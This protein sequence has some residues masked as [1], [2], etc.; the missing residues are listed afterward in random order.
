[1]KEKIKN[2]RPFVLRRIVKKTSSVRACL[3]SFR[4]VRISYIFLLSLV[5]FSAV[6]NAIVFPPTTANAIAAQPTS[7]ADCKAAGGSWTYVS[8]GGANPFVCTIAMVKLM[9]PQEEAAS[10]SYY[11]ALQPCVSNSGGFGTVGM[12][13]DI[14]TNAA[15]D[16]NAAPSTWFNNDGANHTIYPYQKAS[17]A[18]IVTK[19]LSLWGWGS[20]YKSFLTSIGY[21]LEGTNWHGPSDGNA[22]WNQFSAVIRSKVYS[23]SFSSGLP[24]R[25]SAATYVQALD[26]FTS[27]RCNAKD[28]GI[29]SEITNTTYRSWIDQKHRENSSND[30]VKGIIPGASGDIE[31]NKINIVNSAGVIEQHGF[32]YETHDGCD[33]L[34]AI[35]NANAQGWLNWKTANPTRTDVTPPST[36]P[37]ATND[38]G[39]TQQSCNI[40]MVGWL[41]CPV[42]RFMAQIV[43]QAYV[44]ISTMLTTP[45]INT[46]TED[47]NPMFKA[48]SYMRNFANIAFVIAFLIIIFSQLTSVGL[49]NYG[50]KKMLPRLIVAAILVNVSYWICVIAVDISNIL[51]VSLKT[52]MDTGS[53]SLYI[54]GGAAN[55]GGGGG[56]DVLTVGLLGTVG[57]ATVLYLG[58]SILFPMLIAALF[59]IVTVVIVLTMRQALIIILVVISP[60]AFVAYLLPNTEKW[61]NKWR[62]LFQVLLLMFPIIAVIFGGSALASTI[63]ANVASSTPPPNNMILQVMAA[64]ITIIPLFIVPIVMKTAG[65]LLNRFG[66]MVNNPNKGP[67]DRLKKGATNMRNN[68][69]YMRGK[70]IRD[71]AKQGYKDRQ[72]AKRL[73]SGYGKDGTLSGRITRAQAGGVG[74]VGKMA[75]ETKAGQAA[76][77]WVTDKIPD[78]IKNNGVVTAGV[79][80]VTGSQQAQSQAILRAAQGAVAEA[81]RK[82]VNEAKSVLAENSNF[83]KATSDL[84]GSSNKLGTLSKVDVEAHVDFILSSGGEEEVRNIVKSPELMKQFG[85]EVWRAVAR[86][87]GNVRPKNKDIANY[88]TTATADDSTV[89]QPYDP[90]TN[91][92]QATH[93]QGAMSGMQA[94]QLIRTS[95]D[96]LNQPL[97]TGGTAANHINPEQAAVAIA[98]PNFGDAK[99]VTQTAI[100]NAAA[101][102][103]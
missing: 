17:C 95:P 56:W 2:S 39:A 63:I 96:F 66:G 77:S 73:Q 79:A 44:A 80:A 70:R 89:L 14:N 41:V 86:N 53:T 51:G 31:F 20:D 45:A 25:S 58:L 37:S 67:F 103:P 13:G 34:P 65:G 92:A 98:S 4:R 102:R 61:F 46:S 83:Q 47:G 9:S 88:V 21:K 43:D 81:A 19:A 7:E 18:D 101:P 57:A 3:L 69:N 40:D 84:I 15:Q 99:P 74:E 94:A 62:E 60:L 78:A 72:F 22:R 11:A 24:P 52:L 55:S 38:A 90:A 48:W 29:Y 35:I 93:A 100:R 68:S 76:T 1:M 91:V 27:E 71:H 26:S 10:Y 6:S 50:I 97:A 12:K 64:G 28:L 5:I 49:N 85:P 33:Q 59:A 23:N 42:M 16:G 32:A 82:E 54:D 8:G 75:G 30:G 87:D 36:A